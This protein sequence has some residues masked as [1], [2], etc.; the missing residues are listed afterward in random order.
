M[1]KIISVAVT[2]IV[3]S[4]CSTT[5]QHYPEQAKRIQFHDS[6][7]T[8][9]NECTRLGPVGG[10]GGA[11][12]FSNL[13]LRD[14]EKTLQAQAYNLYKA[15]TIATLYVERTPILIYFTATASGIA[16]KCYG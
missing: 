2:S 14:L 11:F 8:L 12:L 3:L 4:A 5:P 10:E 9:L 15:D 16:Y 13:A 7:S 1:L 6:K